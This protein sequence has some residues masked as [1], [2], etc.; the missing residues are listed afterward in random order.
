[1]AGPSIL[2]VVVSDSE[3]KLADIAWAQRH[4]HEETYN[5]SLSNILLFVTVH[6]I[7]KIVENFF[8]LAADFLQCKQR[9]KL[10][11]TQNTVLT[12]QTVNL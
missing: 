12:L 6:D 10:I 11:V 1:M 7:G 5:I 4:A 2:A 8:D 9:I 3:Q